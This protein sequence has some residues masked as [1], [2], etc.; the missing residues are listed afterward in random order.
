M[1]TADADLPRDADPVPTPAALAT[2]TGT[3]DV[4]GQQLGRVSAVDL[5]ADHASPRGCQFL[6][7]ES[8]AWR[9][10]IPSRE[11]R[12]GAFS[13]PAPLAPEKQSR[14]CLAATHVGCATYVA[15]VNA[16]TERLGAAPVRRATR[17]GL[18]R[19]TTVIE[20][21]GGIKARLVGAVLDRRRWPAIP[22]V[23]L[24]TSLFVVALSGL[25]AGVP[26]TA[27]ST[28]GPRPLTTGPVARVASSAPSAASSEGSAIDDSTGPTQ[29]APPSPRSAPTQAPGATAP[30]AT[31]RSY[32]VKS[33]DTLGAI[34]TRFGTTVSVLVGLNQLADAGR[35]SIGQVLLVP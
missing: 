25:R 16:R 18:A 7:A 28:E 33:G 13:P 19:T 23:I 31:H 14:L 4:R 3:L 30:D 22:A 8:G 5:A 15:S 32:R 11:H 29:S 34:A 20:D 1:S 2:P 26:A 12:C 17:W 6:V 10:G 21:A 35:L 24:V 9:L 27:V